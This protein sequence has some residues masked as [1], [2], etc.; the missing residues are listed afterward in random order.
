MG[1][2]VDDDAFDSVRFV[3]FG[4][5]APQGSKTFV[6][7]TE[8]GKG[9]MKESSKK[10]KPWRQEVSA[11]ALAHRRSPLWD[12]AVWLRVTFYTAKPKSRAKKKNRRTTRPDLS[13]LVRSIE[14]AMEGIIYVDDGR[15]EKI[16]AR[17]K[18]GMPARAVIEMWHIPLDFPLT[19]D[20]HDGV[21]D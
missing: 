5:A 7:M 4:D 21:L 20:E 6:G 15:I 16:E 18:Y 14:D 12:Q 19:A 8:S 17:K 9:L 11:T 1:E 10:N 2:V 13:K 3:V